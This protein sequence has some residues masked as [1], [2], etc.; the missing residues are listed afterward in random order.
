MNAPTISHVSVATY[1]G[2]IDETISWSQGRG[3][4]GDANR[5]RSRLDALSNR[6]RAYREA[7]RGSTRAPDWA[8]RLEQRLVV[9]ELLGSLLP[10]VLDDLVEELRSRRLRSRRRPRRVGGPRPQVLR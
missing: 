5:L 3:L 7:E 1:I 4:P 6:D 2:M 10:E 9:D 8:Y